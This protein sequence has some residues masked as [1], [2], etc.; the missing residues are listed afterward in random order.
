MWQYKYT[1]GLNINYPLMHYSITTVLPCITYSLN[2]IYYEQINVL[3]NEMIVLLYSVMSKLVTIYMHLMLMG[4]S[5][6]R[7]TIGGQQ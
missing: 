2:N 7:P 3:C 6:A 4:V 1:V 5:V